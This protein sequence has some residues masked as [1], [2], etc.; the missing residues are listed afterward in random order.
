[1]PI[2]LMEKI[3]EFK[4]YSNT[5]RIETFFAR[6]HDSG[7]LG[8]KDILIQQG[9]KRPENRSI[10]LH[11]LFKRYSNTTRIETLRL[12]LGTLGLHRS[13]DILIQQGLKQYGCSK[14]LHR[15]Q[16]QKIF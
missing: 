13:K 8:S 7:F 16:V 1:M 6:M 10:K 14:D 9:L 5:T 11:F 12:W 3:E 2:P 15:L 4:R